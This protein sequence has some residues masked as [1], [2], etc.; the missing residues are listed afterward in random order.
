MHE[1]PDAAHAILR[2]YRTCEMTTLGRDG[3][4]STWPLCYRLLDDGRFLLSTSIALP[5]KAFNIRREPLVSL[6]VSEPKASGVASPGAV[7]VQGTATAEDRVVTDPSS[8]P[9]VEA[10]FTEN[11]FARQPAGKI[12]SR[13]LGRQLFPAYYMRILMYVTPTRMWWWPSRD[14]AAAP[15][16]LPTLPSTEVRHGVG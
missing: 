16:P 15:Q 1:L 3:A 14:F 8:D 11:V 12:W 13:W 4:P 2:R 5:H 10:Y 6:L 9:D 7:L